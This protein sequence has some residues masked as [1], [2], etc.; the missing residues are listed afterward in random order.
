MWTSEGQAHSNGKV[1]ANSVQTKKPSNGKKGTEMNTT[2]TNE[3]TGQ[4]VKQAAIQLGGEMLNPREQF[5]LDHFG[6][7]PGKVGKKTPAFWIH[8]APS[9]WRKTMKYWAAFYLGITLGFIGG[10]MLAVFVG[11]VR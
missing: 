6:I 8:Q 9:A 1:F 3:L 10:G 5:E 4:S 7:S 11:V 2:H